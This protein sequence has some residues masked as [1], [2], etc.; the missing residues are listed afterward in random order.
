[1]CGKLVILK[2]QA[3]AKLYFRYAAMNAG[4]STSL[5]QAAYNY[6][7][8]GM[9]VVLLTAELDNRGG[10][11]VISSRL[12]LSRPAITFHATHSMAER[13]AHAQQ[14]Q[15]TAKLSCVLIDEAQFLT[16]AQVEELHRWAHAYDIP[17]MCY[18]LRSDF[19]GKAF[20][21][22]ATLLVLADD[23]EEMKTICECGKKASMNARFNDN[24]DRVR[25]GDQVLIGGNGRYRGLCPDCFY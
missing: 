9:A 15:W 18:G 23:I 11:G 24:G 13:I 2:T 7:E 19:Q 12:G 4:K 8:R 3:M 25:E 1:M 22:A 20:A 16:T 6:E 10:V 5:L 17:V 21:G 14:A